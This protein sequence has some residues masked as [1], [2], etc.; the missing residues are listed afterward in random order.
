MNLNLSHNN[1]QYGG[2]KKHYIRTVFTKIGKH[3]ERHEINVWPRGVPPIQT[4]NLIF[5]NHIF[6]IYL[7][8]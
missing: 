2:E 4:D 1:R 6:K 3:K 7:T 5:C 8:F